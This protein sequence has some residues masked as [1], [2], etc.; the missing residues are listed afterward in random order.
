[1]DGREFVERLTVAVRD[2]AIS[3]TLARLTKPA[4]RNPGQEALDRCKWFNALDSQSRYLLQSCIRDAINDT[5]FG[6]LCALDGVRAINDCSSEGHLELHYVTD[7]ST[8]LCSPD[9]PPLHE[10]FEE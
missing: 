6:M 3:G 8:L 9:G 5:I 1:M 2:Q 4:G 10:F 7:T